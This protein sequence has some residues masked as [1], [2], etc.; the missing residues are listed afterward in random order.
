MNDFSSS[1][2]T[3]P[4]KAVPSGVSW[5]DCSGDCRLVSPATHAR[6]NASRFPRRAGVH[7]RDSRDSLRKLSAPSAA[8][9]GAPPRIARPGRLLSRSIS[10]GYP[11]GDVVGADSVNGDSQLG[12]PSA[13]VEA[14]EKVDH[15]LIFQPEVSALMGDEAVA[16]DLMSW[17][18]WR[19]ASIN[20]VRVNHFNHDC[21]VFMNIEARIRKRVHHRIRS[22]AI[23]VRGPA[24]LLFRGIRRSH[25]GG[26]LNRWRRSVV[27]IE[28]PRWKGVA[29]AGGGF[30]GCRGRAFSACSR[31]PTHSGRAMRRRAS[32]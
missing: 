32:P 19:A 31:V 16:Y 27:S 20:R 21:S 2:T 6:A 1:K 22:A 30:E 28:Q 15:P 26:R 11:C 7:R 14:A 18:S 10:V 13:F 24:Y 5:R 12:V 23:T 3:R 4:R 17:G 29:G 8:A 25:F 9:M